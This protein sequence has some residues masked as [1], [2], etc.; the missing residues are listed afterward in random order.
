MV[1]EYEKRINFRISWNLSFSLYFLP[2]AA[3]NKK[4]VSGEKF[5]VKKA[6]AIYMPIRDK[7]RLLNSY[8]TIIPVFLI[9]SREES[10]KNLTN[11]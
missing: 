1:K 2:Q 9:Y 5:L 11:R 8:L 3:K 4:L 10:I 6:E 7:D